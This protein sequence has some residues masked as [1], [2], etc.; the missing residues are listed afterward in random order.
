VTCQDMSPSGRAYSA[1]IQARS[2]LISIWGVRHRRFDPTPGIDLIKQQLEGIIRGTETSM[3]CRGLPYPR[4]SSSRIAAIRAGSLFAFRAKRVSS[5]ITLGACWRASSC[6]SPRTLG[7]PP[8][9]PLWPFRNFNF[10]LSVTVLFSGNHSTTQL[11]FPLPEVG[12]PSDRS[13][14]SRVDDRRRGGSNR[15]ASGGGHGTGR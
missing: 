4:S 12:A 13:A 5:T 15:S 1:P 10:F 8:G 11:A 14:F 3:A 7:R 9:L 2:Q 6:T